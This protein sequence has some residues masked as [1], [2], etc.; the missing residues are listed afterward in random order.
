[1]N[2]L[3]HFI[4]RMSAWAGKAF[5]WCIL[6]LTLAV[7]YEVFV[8]YVL[9]DPTRWA[10]DL[11]YMMY[12]ALFMMG[13]AYALSRES[14][15]RCDMLFRRLSPKVQA[16]I[17]LVLFFVF[18]FPG[19]LALVYAGTRYAYDAVRILEKSVYSPAGM[20][21]YVFKSIIP[22]AGFMIVLQG[23]AECIRCFQC[24]STG[25]WPERLHDVEETEK[26]LIRQHEEEEKR[27]QARQAT[28]A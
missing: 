12:G 14:H 11:S 10:F 7:S 16:G 17:E 23:I 19:A 21:T 27:A 20:P 8:R 28:Q 6:I 2:E 24:L 13:G 1:M 3:V 15:V 26:V 5:G 4:E 22:V 18:F 9:R 25:A